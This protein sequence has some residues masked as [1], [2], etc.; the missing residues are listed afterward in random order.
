MT[1]ARAGS[2]LG[3]A[4]SVEVALEYRSL[5]GLD[6]N[7]RSGEWL[8]TPLPRM[9]APGGF[10]AK[11]ASWAA[12]ARYE[13]RAV[14]QHPVLTLYGEAKSVTLPSREATLPV[15]STARSHGTYDYP[16][17]LESACPQDRLRAR[18]YTLHFQISNS[19][20]Q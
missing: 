5:E 8:R 12:G 18:R 16:G 1:L 4:A 7:E 10:S 9:T 15:V 14:V 6:L 20:W 19:R 13:F 3:D 11:V 17:S 2:A